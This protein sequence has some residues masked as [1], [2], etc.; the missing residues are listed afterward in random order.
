LSE[1]GAGQGIVKFEETDNEDIVLSPGP[2]SVKATLREPKSLKV[3]FTDLR[4]RVE[5]AEVARWS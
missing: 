1:T 3:A 4:G 2:K 5:A